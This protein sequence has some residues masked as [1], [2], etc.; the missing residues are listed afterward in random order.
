MDFRNFAGQTWSNSLTE[1]HCFHQEC[2]WCTVVFSLHVYFPDESIQ[3]RELVSFTA[4]YLNDHSNYIVSL[5][6][7]QGLTHR[8]K[9]NCWSNF[10]YHSSIVQSNSG[11]AWNHLFT[12]RIPHTSLNIN[13][14][15][16]ITSK[17]AKNVKPL[18]KLPANC[19]VA[20]CRRQNESRN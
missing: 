11:R 13:Q 4:V 17:S 15:S 3:R 19:E 16:V 18:W 2:F 1:G 7:T 8:I 14:I 12:V 10:H 9:A 6:K 5:R 20:C